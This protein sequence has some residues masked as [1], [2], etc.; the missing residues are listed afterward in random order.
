MSTTIQDAHANPAKPDAPPKPM[1]I[2][3]TKVRV[4][5][6]GQMTFHVPAGSVIGIRVL[7]EVTTFNAGPDTKLI[8]AGN[9]KVGDVVE[10]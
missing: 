4:V 10:P 5:H 1:A 8:P 7:P 3:L 9:L 2:V 6:Q